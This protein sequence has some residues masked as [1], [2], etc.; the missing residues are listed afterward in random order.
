MQAAYPAAY[1]P[2]GGYSPA[3]AAHDQGQ[4]AQLQQQVPPAGAAG[5][6]VEAQQTQQQQQFAEDD[7]D[8]ICCGVPCTIL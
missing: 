8:C 7:A 1:P 6:D 3:T 4:L 2:G 5:L